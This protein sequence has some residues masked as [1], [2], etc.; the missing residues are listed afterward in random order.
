MSRI[1]QVAVGIIIGMLAMPYLERSLTMVSFA[2]VFGIFVL[3]EYI[4]VWRGL[5]SAHL[6]LLPISLLVGVLGAIFWG[7]MTRIGG[8]GDLLIISVFVLLPIVHS[9]I[10]PK[11]VSADISTGENH[12]HGQVGKAGKFR[13]FIKTTPLLIMGIVI[14]A[15]LVSFGVGG[16]VW[17]NGRL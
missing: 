15:I 9:L 14:S 7:L 2:I 1:F 12:N 16:G 11:Q 13:K 3:S 5:S 17:T 10:A 6:M 8:V 4:A